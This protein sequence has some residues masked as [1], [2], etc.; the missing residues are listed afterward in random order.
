MSES[1]RVRIWRQRTMFLTPKT[2]GQILLVK[3]L[4]FLKSAKIFGLHWIKIPGLTPVEIL[5]YFLKTRFLTPKTHCLCGLSK[6]GAF[7]EYK[8]IG[9]TSYPNPSFQHLSKSWVI[10]YEPCFLMPKKTHGLL[11]LVKILGFSKSAK[12]LGPHCIKV[13]GLTPVEILGYFW[14]TRLL[15]LKTHCL[16]GLSKCWFFFKRTKICANIVS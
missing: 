7:K 2:N 13:P 6:L 4:G 14:R 12:I 16:C 11:L 1:W 15:T 10:S 8:D 5:G 9:P 3:I